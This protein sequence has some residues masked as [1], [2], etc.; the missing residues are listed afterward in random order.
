MPDTFASWFTII[1]LHLWMI[2]ARLMKEETIGY[3]ARDM[4]T[5]AFFD[6]VVHRASLLGVRINFV[7]I[8]LR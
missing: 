6:D 5:T 4:L 3:Y 8:N 7:S 2:S 1:E